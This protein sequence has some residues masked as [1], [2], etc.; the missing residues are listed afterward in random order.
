MG[1]YYAGNYTDIR[2]RTK[3]SYKKENFNYGT[4]KWAIQYLASK[5]HRDK[6]RQLTVC[7]FTVNELLSLINEACTYCDSNSEK[8]GMDRI[9]N[10]KGHTKDNVVAC[11]PTCNS[12]RMDNLTFEE[13]KILGK[14]IKLI[15]ENRH[16]SRVV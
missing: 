3:D 11:C 6:K 1:R 2:K 4:E 15:K 5:R 12:A 14:T 7:D 8:I 10:T 16:A 9:D 13:M